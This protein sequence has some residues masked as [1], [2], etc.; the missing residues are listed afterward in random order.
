M[1]KLAEFK[2][3][4]SAQREASDSF[5]P[6]LEFFW[7][8]KMK[9]QRDEIW[10]YLS[11]TSRFNRELG[12]SPRQQVEREGKITV[13]TSML[14][15]PQQWV[16][17]PWTWLAGQTITSQRR[18]IR[19][20]AK[21]VYS[22][23]HIEEDPNSKDHLVFIYFG[24]QPANWF[25][26]QFLL[27]TGPMIRKRFSDALNKIDQHLMQN[28]KRSENAFKVLPPPLSDSALKKLVEIKDHLY[29][30]ELQREIT[31]QLIEFVST[32]DDLDLEPIRILPLARAW[33]FSERDLLAT[34]LHA[35]RLGLLQIS[36]EVI[37][38]HCRGSRFTAKSLG[39]LPATAD[40]DVCEIDFSTSDANSIE[41]MFHVHPSIRKVEA[42]LFCAAEPAK[43][44][45]IKVQQK[46]LPRQT[47]NIESKLKD[48]VY[49]SRFVGGDQEIQIEIDHREPPTTI[50]LVGATAFKVGTPAKIR[51]T[52]DSDESRIFVIEELWWDDIALKPAV[53]LSLPEF[54]DLFAE[55]HLS[56][57]VKLFLGEQ[58]ILFT[59]IVGSTKFYS[60]V[61]DAKAFAE[62]RTHF[63]EVFEVVQLHK[64]VVVK[65]IGDAVMASF[66]S[67]EQAVDAAIAIQL[68]FPEG[69]TDTCIRLRISV[70]IGPVIA[71]HLN[72]GIDYF[73]NTVNFA[74][75]IQSC[76]GAG[77]VAMSEAI[78]QI[79]LRS[80]RQSLP[81]HKREHQPDG[82]APLDV[83]VLQIA[84]GSKAAA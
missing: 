48:G 23:F 8:F 10:P 52:N 54:R 40:C 1:L 84:S 47:V 59:D 41:V 44:N 67:A 76:A 50:D 5:S 2:T 27:L 71:V 55:E 12:F 34:C 42:L 35:T 15:I 31:D 37:C 77:E 16:E 39:D 70:H 25:W 24:W 75:K 28:R 62:V 64:G 29:G 19:G 56:S 80:A 7:C 33:K 36:W 79:Y 13:S 63:Q 68:R 58:A 61:G 11:D 53:V 83:H 73:G 38:P 49:R 72:T 78:Y 17:E 22:I 65:T 18:Y 82:F 45:H 66:P 46:L 26:R 21:N 9:S 30:K 4:L 81:I 60:N 20:M 32:G 74:A 69:R 51:V 14:G 57:N 43:K 3:R 6:T